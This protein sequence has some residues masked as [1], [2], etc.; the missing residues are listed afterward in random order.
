MKS[1]SVIQGWLNVYKPL[2]MNSTRAVTIVRHALNKH[3][4]GHAGT[5]DPLAEGVLPLA[6]GDATKTVNYLMEKTKVYEFEITWGAQTSTDDSEGDIVASSP[7]RPTQEQINEAIPHFIGHQDQIPPQYSA[8]WIEGKRAY[9]LARQ[10]K[11]MD[12]QARNIFI[13]SLELTACPSTDRATF[14]VICGK[15]TYVRSLARDLAIHLQTR[16]HI[17]VLKRVRVGNFLAA[18]AISLEKI[19]EL[20]HKVLSEGYVHPIVDVLDDIPAIYVNAE[21]EM[22]IR[23]GHAIGL[24][25]QQAIGNDS[26]T[27]LCLLEPKKALAIG[28]LN[29]GFVQPNRVFNKT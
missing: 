28:T 1:I 25:P 6:L 11:Q 17:S 2:G 27:V 22:L 26:G 21:Q 24:T 13:E 3:K 15:G 23:H 14:R 12:I 20:G 29:S 4:V 7:H 10:N 16:G 9:D 5:L 18:N 8:V 19:Q